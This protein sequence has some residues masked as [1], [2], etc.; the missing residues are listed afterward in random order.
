MP[1]GLFSDMQNRRRRKRITP[2]QQALLDQQGI[3]PEEFFADRETWAGAAPTHEAA[4]AELFAD[5]EAEAGAGLLA[6]VKPAQKKGAKWY[7]YVGLAGAGFAQAGGREG[8][9]RNYVDRFT[10]DQEKDEWENIVGGLGITDP[11]E[12]E[13]AKTDKSG[14]LAARFGDK[15]EQR[16]YDRGRTDTVADSVRERSYTVQDRDLDLGERRETRAQQGSQFD[17]TLGQDASQHSDTMGLSWATLAGNREDKA[18]DREAEAKATERQPIKGAQLMSAYNRANDFL[19]AQEKVL[20]DALA[21]ANESAGFMAAA[22]GFKSQGSSIGDG[23]GRFFSGVTGGTV[24]TLNRHTKAASALMKKPGGGAWTDADQRI[25]ESYVVN[26]ENNPTTNRFAAMTAINRANRQ[27]DYVDFLRENIDLNDPESLQVARQVWGD[28]AREVSM[29][30]PKSKQPLDPSQ[31]VGFD[32][33]VE[34][35]MASGQGLGAQGGTP[36]GGDQTGAAVDEFL[37]NV[38]ANP[39]ALAQELAEFDGTFG[40]GAARRMV[41]AKLG[42]AAAAALFGQ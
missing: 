10:A 30:D 29:F 9:V 3:T 32:Q 41:E 38:K 13:L 33:W 35:R 26:A 8:A 1:E 21:V 36:S 31:V 17:R 14:Y 40:Q 25:A 23:F 39:A 4:T 2:E 12:A 19:S 42:K 16:R 34:A 6:D 27:R 20:D 28:Y 18:L 15:T 22:R 11:F 37:K 5:D 24:N 7:D